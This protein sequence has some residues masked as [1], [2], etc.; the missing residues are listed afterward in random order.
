MVEHVPDK[1]GV[2]GS[3]PSTPTRIQLKDFLPAKQWASAMEAYQKSWRK[4]K[5]VRKLALFFLFLG[6]FDRV[7]GIDVLLNALRIF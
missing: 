4:V 1:N 2:E 3:I 5:M 6:R 7:K